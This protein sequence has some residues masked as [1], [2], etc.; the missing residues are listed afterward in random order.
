MIPFLFLIT[1]SLID[2]V[3]KARKKNTLKKVQVGRKEVKII[4]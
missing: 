2:L 1:E 3:R 4:L